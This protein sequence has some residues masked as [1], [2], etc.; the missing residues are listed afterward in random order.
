M[1]ASIAEHFFSNDDYVTV[2]LGQRMYL[3]IALAPL[4]PDATIAPSVVAKGQRINSST[5]SPLIRRGPT[6]PSG[7]LADPMRFSIFPENCSVE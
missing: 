1:I 6:T 7:I 5:W 2:E 3:V 4:V